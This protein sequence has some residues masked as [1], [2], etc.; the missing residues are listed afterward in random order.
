M[1]KDVQPKDTQAKVGPFQL[2]SLDEPKDKAAP[3]QFELFGAP[4]DAQ[5]KTGLLQR[6]PFDALESE[7][8]ETEPL[9]VLLFTTETG[10]H[11]EPLFTTE[12]RAGALSDKQF[13]NPAQEG[14]I[15]LETDTT[16]EVKAD[17]APEI[18]EDAAPNV[19][20]PKI[21]SEDDEPPAEDNA[22]APAQILGIDSFP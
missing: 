11:F 21:K 16:T 10:P 13:D 20:E 14:D 18:E 19:M 17:A 8:S 12:A 22:Q 1:P 5:A 3:S 7:A 6:K 9:F 2:E 4:K 15:A